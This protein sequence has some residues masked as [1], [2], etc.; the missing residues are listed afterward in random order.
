MTLFYKKIKSPV[1]ELKL[2][3]SSNALVAVLWE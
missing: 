1:G 3:A 2:V